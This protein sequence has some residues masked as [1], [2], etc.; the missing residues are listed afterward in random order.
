MRRFSRPSLPQRRSG[1]SL[2]PWC[3][4]RLV[5]PGKA[6]GIE[7]REVGMAKLEY[8][9]WELHCHSAV[10][11]TFRAS[12]RVYKGGLSYQSLFETTSTQFC[13]DVCFLK[14]SFVP[15]IPLLSHFLGCLRVYEVCCPL[16]YCST[17]L[18][19]RQ[20]SSVFFPY[21]R[22]CRDSYQN[23]LNLFE[24]VVPFNP[25]KDRDIYLGYLF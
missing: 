21:S 4:D 23:S 22:N 11:Q 13:F 16:C 12:A 5:L 8:Q 18:H 7:I 17:L 9:V 14:Y 10:T 6:T 2:P 3:C 15:L 25:S 24:P 20:G 19:F 1:Y